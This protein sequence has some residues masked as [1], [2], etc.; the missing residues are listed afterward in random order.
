[1]TIQLPPD[2]TAPAV[3]RAALAPYESHLGPEAMDD[4]RL[5]TTE[6]AAM[7]VGQG[8]GRG[9]MKVTTHLHADQLEV[10]VDCAM[11]HPTR[12]AYSCADVG[13]GALRRRVLDQLAVVWDVR[14]KAVGR[15]A[16]AAFALT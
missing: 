11:G 5:L 15:L 16:W 12:F 14:E 3:A 10:E 9:R 4:L 7:C 6:L 13:E 1:M 8:P 2:S